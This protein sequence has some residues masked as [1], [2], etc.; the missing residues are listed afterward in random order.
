MTRSAS[1]IL[2]YRRPPVGDTPVTDTA[3]RST[4]LRH[5]RPAVGR[6]ST[7][8]VRNHRAGVWIRRYRSD[9]LRSHSSARR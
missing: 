7:D 5:P 1:Q 4:A 9:G 2:T 3:Y 8:S 6:H